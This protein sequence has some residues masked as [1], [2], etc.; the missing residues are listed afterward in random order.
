[1]LGTMIGTTLGVLAMH[2]LWLWTCGLPGQSEP[3]ESITLCF[4]GG[5]QIHSDWEQIQRQKQCLEHA[6]SRLHLSCQALDHITVRLVIAEI[7]LP[8]AVELADPLLR[9]RSGFLSCMA[10]QY[11]GLSHQQIVAR[12]LIQRAERMYA[13]NDPSFWQAVAQRLEREYA[14]LD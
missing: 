11:I 4:P 8:Q 5:L 9:R 14:A 3:Q 1:M 13:A 6:K 2:S 12:F 10:G 7:A